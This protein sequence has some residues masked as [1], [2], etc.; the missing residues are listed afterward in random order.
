[1]AAGPLRP[2]EAAA[3]RDEARDL[4]ARVQRIRNVDATWGAARALSA[5][6]A[7][8]Q[9]LHC[10]DAQFQSAAF[11]RLIV[12]DRLTG[13]AADIIGGPNVQLHHTKIF[14]KP[15]EKGSPFP[16]H[17]DHP[18]FPHERHSMIMWNIAGLGVE[19]TQLLE[20]ASAN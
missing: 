14:I 11:A 20:M 7:G 9:V 18:F 13:A 6:A 15:A 16:L 4:I 19:G 10:H 3:Y 2:E 5:E 12:D 1:M 17:Q 8:T